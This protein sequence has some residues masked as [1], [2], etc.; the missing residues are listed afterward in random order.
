[1]DGR[2]IPDL[3]DC[4]VELRA[5]QKWISRNRFDSNVKY[6]IASTTCYHDLSLHGTLPF[7]EAI[8]TYYAQTQPSGQA[9]V[10]AQKRNDC[11]FSGSP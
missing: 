5:I 8:Y 1:M 10:G 3:R 7:P 4:S 9:G 2:Y 11:S 6:L